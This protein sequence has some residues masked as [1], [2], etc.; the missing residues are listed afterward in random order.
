MVRGGSWNNNA[1][2]ARSAYRNQN[3]PDNVNSNQGFRLCLS[4]MN[5]GPWRRPV[6][7]TRRRV[8]F[9]AI[10]APWTNR[11]T[12]GVVVDRGVDAPCRSLAGLSFTARLGA[13]RDRELLS[14]PLP[15]AL[16]RCLGR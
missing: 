13:Y 16:R 4:S 15:A 12:P 7:W 1:R 11:K 5:G 10:T 2:N 14:G 9:R 8:P 3:E 6:T